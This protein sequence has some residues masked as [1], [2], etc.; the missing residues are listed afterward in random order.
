MTLET[1]FV[2]TGA[3]I[4]LVMF[5]VTVMKSVK[6]WHRSV[7]DIRQASDRATKSLIEMGERLEKMSMA[8]QEELTVAIH[9]LRKSVNA[10]EEPMKLFAQFIGQPATMSE[11]LPSL[12]DIEGQNLYS[13]I[14]MEQTMNNRMER[15]EVSEGAL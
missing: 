1:F 11:G 9:G 6:I 13:G 2:V 14:Q 3:E 5:A 4:I 15:D 7:D 12:E 10:L 8:T